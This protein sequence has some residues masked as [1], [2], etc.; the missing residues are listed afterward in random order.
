MPFL[1]TLL[2][3]S[4]SL[5]G[6][7]ALTESDCRCRTNENADSINEYTDDS[8]FPWQVS[9]GDDHWAEKFQASI[10]KSLIEPERKFEL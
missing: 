1:T 4:W 7:L 10:N 5:S 6:S 3:L 2:V 8:Q 9:L